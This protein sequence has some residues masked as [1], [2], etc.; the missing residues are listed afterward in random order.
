MTDDEYRPPS[1]TVEIIPPG[2]RPD[3]VELALDHS[4]IPAGMLFLA[5]WRWGSLEKA[6]LKYNSAVAAS[7]AKNVAV[8]SWIRSWISLQHTWD[9]YH[10]LDN[11]RAMRRAERKKERTYQIKIND[12]DRQISLKAKKI[13]AGVWEEPPEDA[14]P[15]PK[16]QVEQDIEKMQVWVNDYEAVM[17]WVEDHAEQQLRDAG[18]DDEALADF[19]TMIA[20]I[21]N[22]L[23]NRATGRSY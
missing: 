10:D 11:V 23:K 21:L 12:L 1:G 19:N 13:E 17:A 16:S 5:R 7:D 18:L 22:D 20:R 9:D 3:I 14:P 8:E 6:I 4:D 15:E 2:R